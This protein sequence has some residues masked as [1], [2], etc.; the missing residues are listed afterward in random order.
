MAINS[1]AY[2]PL[3]MMQELANS[4]ILR[5]DEHIVNDTTIAKATQ[6]TLSASSLFL[7]SASSFLLSVS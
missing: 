4:L 1:L 5:P 6:S 7:S 2:S 3:A